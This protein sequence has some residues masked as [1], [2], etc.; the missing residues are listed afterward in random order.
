MYYND[1]TVVLIIDEISTIDS[2]LF[3]VLDKIARAVRK[4]KDELFGDLLLIA[5]GDFFQLPPVQGD[6]AFNCSSWKQMHFEKI[7]LKVSKRHDGDI[8]FAQI[9]N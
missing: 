5:V 7:E 4:R 3:L 9:L 2:S 8:K 6:D 1:E